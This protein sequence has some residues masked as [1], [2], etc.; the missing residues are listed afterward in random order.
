MPTRLDAKAGVSGR[1]DGAPRIDNN[2]IAGQFCFG[3]E[4]HSEARTNKFLTGVRG[5]AG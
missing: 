1:A 2:P 4:K 3:T 5:C